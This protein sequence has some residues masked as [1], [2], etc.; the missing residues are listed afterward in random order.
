MA[1]V[2]IA[3]FDAVNSIEP[4]YRPY[5]AQLPAMPDTSKDAAAAA[6]AGAVLTNLLPDAASDIQAALRSYLSAIPDSDAKSNGIKLG[7]AVAAKMPRGARP[8]TD[9]STADAYRPRDH[10][11]RLYPD[12]AHGRPAMARP[13]AVCDDQPL[14]VPAK[15]TDRARERP[16]GQRL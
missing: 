5:Q 1:I 3:M 13:H 2:H 7:D 10:A 8:T 11:R 16:M 15:T 4:L 9:A 6:A 14:P 12:G